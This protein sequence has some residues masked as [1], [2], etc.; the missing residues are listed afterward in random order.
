MNN[1]IRTLL[2]ILKKQKGKAIKLSEVKQLIEKK[3][4]VNRDRQ[5]NL[6]DLDAIFKELEDFKLIKRKNKFIIPTFPFLVEGTLSVAKSS[7][8]FGMVESKKDIF[9]PPKFRTGAKH[10][11]KVLI[12]TFN[13][14]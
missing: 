10:R 4:N 3:E 7:I 8:A 9:I 6:Y 13:K 5:K 1:K 12:E 2:F 14:N 11:D